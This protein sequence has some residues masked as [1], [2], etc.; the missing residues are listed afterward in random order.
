MMGLILSSD[1]VRKSVSDETINRAILSTIGIFT[2]M[3]VLGMVLTISGHDL[4]LFGIYLFILLS[5]LL[6]F[7]LLSLFY[8][9]SDKTYMIWNYIGLFLFSIYVVYDLNIILLKRPF[10]EDYVSSSIGL[11]LDFINIFERLL[12]SKK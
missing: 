8:T 1:I 4:S 3:F 6:I 11:Y 10:G 7:Q 2:C 12:N 9:F 5:I